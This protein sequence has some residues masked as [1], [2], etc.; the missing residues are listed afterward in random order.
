[1]I[2]NAG[3]RLEKEKINLLPVCFSKNYQLNAELFI[4]TWSLSESSKS[5]QDYVNSHNFFGAKHFLLSFQ[6]SGKKLPYAGR[7]G[8]IARCRGAVI[9]SIKFLPGN[10][11]AFK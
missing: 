10:Y 7:L 5:V 4:A 11:Y 3:A 2:D 9:Q 8:E 1:M 6:K